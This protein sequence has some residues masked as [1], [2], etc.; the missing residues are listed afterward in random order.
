MDVSGIA[1]LSS[2]V[3]QVQTGDAIGVL[4]LKKAM[5]ADAQSALQLI[6][7]LPQPASNPSH[8][9]QSVDVKA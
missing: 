9:G 2:S 3:S 6:Q 7:S 8:L 5:N 4:V 1:G